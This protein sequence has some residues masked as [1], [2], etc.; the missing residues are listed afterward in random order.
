MKKTNLDVIISNPPYTVPVGPNETPKQQIMNPDGKIETFTGN[1][2]Y[3]EPDEEDTQ[4]VQ[5][6]NLDTG[7][8]E[9]FTKAQFLARL[10]EDDPNYDPEKEGFE[11]A[12]RQFF[13]W[14]R[15]ET[16]EKEAV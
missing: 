9:T 14:E 7:E 16:Q 13:P 1:P 6:K 4:Q 2:L 3:R 8:V 10:K 11:D 12:W 15:I 5:L